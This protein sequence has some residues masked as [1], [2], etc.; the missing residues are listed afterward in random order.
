MDARCPFPGSRPVTPVLAAPL[1]PGNDEARRWARDELSDREY[2]PPEPSWWERFSERVWEWVADNV[3]DLFG[4]S[5]TLRAIVLVVAVLLV[6]GLAFV[7]LRH[8]RR[9]PRIPAADSAKSTEVVVTGAPQTAK[10]LRAD[11][12]RLHA[13]GDHDAAVIAA[14][15]ALARRAV[16]RSLLADE[17]SLTAHEVASELADRFVGHRVELLDAADLFDAIAYGNRH[18][19]AES[20]RAVIDLERTVGSASPTE[21]DPARPRRLAV[22]R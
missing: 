15:R 2:Q 4:E 7:V 16:E 1:D 20:A 18:A 10:E 12:E 3:L 8:V 5:D 6:I 14:V 22:P 11:A 13:A 19:S 9:A 17:P 21:P